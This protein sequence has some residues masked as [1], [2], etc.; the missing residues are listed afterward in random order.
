MK[1]KANNYRFKLKLRGSY[2]LC[3][4]YVG[5]VIYDIVLLDNS[6]AKQ[7]PILIPS[8]KPNRS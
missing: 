1:T 2:W 3:R 4:V 8:M 7:M 5:I 6:P